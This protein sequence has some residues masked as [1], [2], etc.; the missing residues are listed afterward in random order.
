V[1]PYTFHPE[2]EIEFADAVSFYESRNVGLGRSFAAEVNQTVSVIREHPD[3]G[4][5]IGLGRR[6]M[7]VHRFPYSVV[8]RQDAE[9]LVIIA[10]AHHRRRPG[11][12]RRRK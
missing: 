2:A 1:I 10:V 5:P 12:W 7:L 11:Y 9:S 4:S 6:R 8:Y 3:T